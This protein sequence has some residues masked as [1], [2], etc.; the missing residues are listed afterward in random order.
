MAAMLG[1]G[2]VLFAAVTYWLAHRPPPELKVVP[3]EI[4]QLEPEVDFGGSLE[5][6]V[7]GTADVDTGMEGG[8]GGGESVGS[9]VPSLPSPPPVEPQPAST[10]TIA[11][12]PAAA[13]RA[14][15]DERRTDIVPPLLQVPIRRPAP[16]TG[17]HRVRVVSECCC[18]DLPVRQP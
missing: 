14:R 6:V 16:R 10:S 17:S 15:W 13:A 1:V 7:G 3:L 4:V 8:G 12:A 2:A 11:T 5:G 18:R 9:D